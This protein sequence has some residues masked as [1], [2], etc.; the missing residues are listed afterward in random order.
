MSHLLTKEKIEEIRNAIEANQV[1]YL[2]AQLNELYPADIAEIIDRI[3]ADEAHY[4]LSLLHKEEAAE[5]L[6]ELDEDVREHLV[7]TLSSTELAHD[8]IDNLDSDD[9]ADLINELPGN[10]RQDVLSKITD[11][12]QAQNIADLLFYPENTAGSLMAKELIKVNIGW[13]VVTCIR[14]MRAQAAHVEKVYHVYVVNDQDVLLGLLS[15]ERLLIASPRDHIASLYDPDVISVKAY[16]KAEE[17]A[18]IMKKYDLVALPVIDEMGRLIGRITIDDVL[19]FVQDEAEKDYQLMSGISHDIESSDKVWKLTQGRL[20]WLVVALFGGIIGSRV[21]SNYEDQI[22]IYPEMAFFMPLIA[23][24]AGN[25]GV[26]SSALIVQAL[27]NNSFTGGLLN[28]L[29]KELLVGLINGVACSILLLGYS[30]F[31]APSF[32]LSMTVSTA[33]LTVILFAS[34]FGTFIPLALNKLKIDPALATGPFITTSNDIVGL[35]I[36][37]SIGRLMYGMFG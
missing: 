34:M 24:M 21:I 10:M 8:V 29:G 17:V 6:M 26:Q 9:A 18:S 32:A 37:F 7:S 30:Y 20:F 22:S 11:R 1:D 23:A 31:Y 4:L 13:H 3:D 14:E 36:Y 2:L 19:D 28:K 35:F 12:N 33:L 27:A 5:V 15:L 16:Q 25:V